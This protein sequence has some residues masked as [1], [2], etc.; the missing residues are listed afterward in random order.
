MN[1]IDRIFKILEGDQPEPPNE[2]VKVVVKEEPLCGKYV[3]FSR[4]TAEEN[5]EMISREYRI[6]IAD[7][8]K[9]YIRT[10]G[11]QTELYLNEDKKEE[12]IK[13]LTDP[14]TNHRTGFSEFFKVKVCYGTRYYDS[15]VLS[16]VEKLFREND[17]SNHQ[18]AIRLYKELIEL[19][20]EFKRFRSGEWRK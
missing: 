4:A 18:K 3:K 6:R 1:L 7:M 19:R 11:W 13:V 16:D 14:T 9:K 17:I 5:P 20:K 15:F 12:L 10:Y 8:E 2:R